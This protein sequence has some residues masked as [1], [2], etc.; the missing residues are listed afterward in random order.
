M[1]ESSGMGLLPQPPHYELFFPAGG[2][3]NSRN[4]KHIF[5]KEVSGNVVKDPYM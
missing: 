4:V 5:G 3:H 2:N 1:W